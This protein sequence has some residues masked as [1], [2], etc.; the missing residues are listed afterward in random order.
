VWARHVAHQIPSAV[1]LT[2][3][4]DGHSSSWRGPKSATASA[5]ADYLITGR[6]P[7][8]GTHLGS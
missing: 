3:D 5:I 4:G 8:R 1:L 2:R 6:R 7:A